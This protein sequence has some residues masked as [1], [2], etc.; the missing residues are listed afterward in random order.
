MVARMSR[1][2][3][4]LVRISVL[5]ALAVAGCWTSASAQS[6]D[7][8]TGDAVLKHPAGQLAVKAAE[9]LVAGKTE[10]V[11]ALG[12]KASQGEW[13]QASADDRKGMTAMMLRRAPALAGFA[14]SIRKSGVLATM[15]NS[16]ILRVELAKGD[17]AITY[18]ELE[19]GAWR[20]T[21]GPMVIAGAAEPANETRI[22]G[23][24]LLK[25]PIAALASQYVELVHANKI[26]DAM[27]LASTEAQ[28]EWKAEPASE[29]AASADFR[30]KNLPAVAEFKSLLSSAAVLIIEDGE[31]A[32]LNV[33]R[34]ER[35]PTQLGTVEY[36]STTFAIPFVLENG[37][38]KLAR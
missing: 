3:A 6:P 16:A 13:K 1:P 9:L 18:F 15:G 28:Q 19:A 20:I 31:R 33:I 7:D 11:I 4:S 34:Q 35:R 37:V 27:Q 12:T 25:H 30:K 23:A 8:I 32:T 29:R 24:D 2:V 21:N 14:D 17:A 22:E 10:A 36:T 5:T 38:W 26:E